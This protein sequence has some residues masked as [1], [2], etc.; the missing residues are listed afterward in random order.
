MVTSQALA[1][2]IIQ[3]LLSQPKRLDSTRRQAPGGSSAVQ[4]ASHLG[5]LLPRPQLTGMW[6]AA[7]G[8][9][10]C[11]WESSPWD[12]VALWLFIPPPAYSSSPEHF[13]HC[14]ASSTYASTIVR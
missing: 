1:V 11:P 2:I 14:L 10:G 8:G 4:K 3:P 5:C 7:A 6:E 9:A 12:P 13:P